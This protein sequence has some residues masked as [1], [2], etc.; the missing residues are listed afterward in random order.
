MGGWGGEGELT[1]V[2]LDLSNKRTT[3]QLKINQS[4][5]MRPRGRIHQNSRRRRRLSVIGHS[6][7]LHPRF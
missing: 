1:R 3:G 4:A 5:S 7:C 2:P 6:G